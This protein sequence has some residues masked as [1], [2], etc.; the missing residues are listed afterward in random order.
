MTFSCSAL[1]PSYPN[2]HQSDVLVYKTGQV[3]QLSSPMS[4]M[5]NK[6][7]GSIFL[8]MPRRGTIG[9]VQN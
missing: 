4:D 6:K 2:K 1:P 8:D 9:I 7:S 3:Y 5:M